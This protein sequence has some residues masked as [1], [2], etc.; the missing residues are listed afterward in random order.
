MSPGREFFSSLLKSV[1]DLQDLQEP[2][3]AEVPD[4]VNFLTAGV[5]VQS[6]GD[7]GGWFAVKV[8]GWSHHE[9]ARVIGYW[10]LRENPLTTADAW[11]GLEAFLKRGF[12][13]GDGKVHYIQGAAIDSGGHYTQEVY[14]F[15]EKHRRR[16]WWAV[17]GRNNAAGKRSDSIWPAKISDNGRVYMIDVDIAK[18]TLFR[19]LHGDA[20]A[21]N[22][23]TFPLNALPGAVSMDGHFFEKLTRER[24]EY[25]PGGSGYKWTSPR[26][27]EPWDTLVYAYAAVHG[28][29]SLPG[30]E[31]FKK[32]TG[33][34]PEDIRR[35]AENRAK[36][37]GNPRKADAPSP[38][39]Q[40]T[41][42][43]K[44]KKKKRRW[45]V[46]LG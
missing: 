33:P 37:G 7:D 45:G 19:R 43:A 21:R 38:A 3:D 6:G 24:K 5:D 36:R 42:A 4:D 18:D 16:R 27:Q 8:V 12:R 26:D 32:L 15:A 2:Y 10:E 29:R 40:A 1:H 14:D 41:P 13:D 22:A 11:L 30:G 46:Q 28:L 23:V 31:T 20:D 39:A 17:K 25:V 44:P 35:A 9:R 34:A